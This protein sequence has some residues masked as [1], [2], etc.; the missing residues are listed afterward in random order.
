MAPLVHAQSQPE[1]RLPMA[2]L[3]CSLAKI[4]QVLRQSA[5]GRGFDV[6]GLLPLACLLSWRAE[7]EGAGYDACDYGGLMGAAANRRRQ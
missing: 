1:R 2:S 3:S 7:G 4:G 5:W 6:H